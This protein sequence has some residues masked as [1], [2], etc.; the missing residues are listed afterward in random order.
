MA[1]TPWLDCRSM[2]S[3]LIAMRD[4]GLANAGIVYA[5]PGFASSHILGETAW[6]I[7]MMNFWPEV[8]PRIVTFAKSPPFYANSDDQTLMNDAIVSAVIGNRTFLGST[9][10]YEARNRYNPNAIEWNSVPESKQ[11]GRMMRLMWS[12]KRSEVS[13]VPWASKDCLSSAKCARTT[14]CTA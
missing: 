10:R 13:E 12:R 11:E 3:S 5:R 14:R 7:Q 2:K 8:V 6:R 9:A 4:T 1:H